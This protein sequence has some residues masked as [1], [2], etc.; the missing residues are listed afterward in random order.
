MTETRLLHSARCSSCGGDASDNHFDR[1]LCACGVMH[2]CC[3]ACG[4][5][6]DPCEYVEWEATLAD[7]LNDD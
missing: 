1:S 5:P 4:T 2:T 3:N 6:L 7:G